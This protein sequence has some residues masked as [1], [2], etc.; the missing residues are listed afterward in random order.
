MKITEVHIS[1]IKVGDT[2]VHHGQLKTVCRRA[3]GY[4]SFHGILLWGDS[5]NSGHILV[6]R[7]TFPRWYK[8][9]KV[10]E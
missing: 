3:F 2:V 10:E 6:Q 5:Y 9:V 4:N 7:V 8:G 1:E